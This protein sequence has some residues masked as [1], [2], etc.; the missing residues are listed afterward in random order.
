MDR[1]QLNKL[2][3]LLDKKSVIERSLNRI[4][5]N[6]KIIEDIG[7]DPVDL[8]IGND[9]ISRYMHREDRKIILKTMQEV[10]GREY[11]DICKECDSYIISKRVE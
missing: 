11:K 7:Q 10:V 8:Y 3:K 9:Y 4:N 1:E 6:L 5:D 2:S